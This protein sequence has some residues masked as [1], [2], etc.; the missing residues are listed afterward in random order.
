MFKNCIN[1][2]DL[3]FTYFTTN[4]TNNMAGIL[5]GFSLKSLNLKNFDTKKVINMSYLFFEC[6]AIHEIILGNF[7]TSNIIDMKYMFA[8]CVTLSSLNLINFKTKK[9][10][11]IKYMFYSCQYLENLEIGSVF[12]IPG[13]SDFSYYFIIVIY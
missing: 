4:E 8:D 9:V 3:D 6:Y 13:V 2:K 12:I 11:K 7:D 1:L 5:Y 10:K